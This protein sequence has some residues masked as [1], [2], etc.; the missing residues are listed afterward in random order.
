MYDGVIAPPSAWL[1]SPE[2]RFA[3]IEEDLLIYR[4]VSY[5]ALIRDKGDGRTIS[6]VDQEWP[7]V[8]TSGGETYDLSARFIYDIVF[9]LETIQSCI[10]GLFA[11]ADQLSQ[12]PEPQVPVRSSS[13]PR[14]WTV[15]SKDEAL[16]LALSGGIGP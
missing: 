13:K 12:A 5:D 15:T 7:I 4:I 3:V 9:G 16:Q 6:I 14:V 11:F 2:A 1:I 8:V 10:D